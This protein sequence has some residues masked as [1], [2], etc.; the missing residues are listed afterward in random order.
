ML[1]SYAPA[2]WR[3]Q[4][5]DINRGPPHLLGDL[6]RALALVIKGDLSEASRHLAHVLRIVIN[7]GHGASPD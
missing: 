5:L 1:W 7:F 3:P 4:R 2:Q 6:L